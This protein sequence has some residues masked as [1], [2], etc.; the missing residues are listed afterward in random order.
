M[1]VGQDPRGVG[2][3]KWMGGLLIAGVLSG[4]GIDETVFIPEYADLY[5]EAALRCGDPAVLVFDGLS[6]MEDCLSVIGPEIEG[7]VA[8]CSYRGGK[9]KKC[10]EAM[11][12]L[13]CPPEG[14]SIDEVLPLDCAAALT[15]CAQVVEPVGSTNTSGGTGA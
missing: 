10:L 12:D 2:M 3:R 1:D 15:E 5:C 4:C 8:R 7:D 6:T 11:Q 13:A 14:T 9:A